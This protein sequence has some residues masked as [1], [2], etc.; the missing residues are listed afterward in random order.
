MLGQQTMM[1]AASCSA[2]LISMLVMCPQTAG[3]SG[4]S[5]I[6]DPWGQP[7]VRELRL[8]QLSSQQQLPQKCRC[9]KLMPQTV[10]LLSLDCDCVGAPS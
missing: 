5:C 6:L 2:L 4:G 7:D 3:M 1:G 10:C 8:V 9:Y